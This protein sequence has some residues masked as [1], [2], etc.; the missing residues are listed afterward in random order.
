MVYTS[1]YDKLCSFRN[2]E[3]A[4]R[5]AR[6]NKRNT[7]AVQDFEF[8]LESNLL[9]IKHELETGT[10]KPY[11]LRHFIIRDPKTRLISA[12]PIENISSTPSSCGLPW[13]KNLT[14]AGTYAGMIT[15]SRPLMSADS[16]VTQWRMLALHL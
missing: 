3:L 11:P 16:T 13:W 8:N 1:L 10:Y 9:G 4:F 2:L 12:S 15:H 5:K 6:K 14:V 7:K